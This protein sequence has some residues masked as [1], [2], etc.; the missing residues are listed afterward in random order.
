MNLRNT[1]LDGE[2]LLCPRCGK[3]SLHHYKVVSEFRYKED[4]SAQK[5]IATGGCYMVYLDED[6]GTKA[7]PDT[8]I[9]SRVEQSS[10]PK[11]RRDNIYISFCCEY[12]G[13]I[14]NRCVFF[15]TREIHK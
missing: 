14:K 8:T 2:S 9:S 15:N 6:N 11:N 13:I 3:Q 1:K 12:C 5:T 4:C 7:S 10:N